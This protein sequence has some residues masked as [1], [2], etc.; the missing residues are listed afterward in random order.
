MDPAIVCRGLSKSFGAR[1]AVRSL[2]L[3]VDAGSIV[4][5]LGPNGA[6]KTTVIRV[7]TTILAPDSGSFAIAGAPHLQP[8]RIRRRVG[9]LPESSGFPGGAT[10]EQALTF[11]A[12]LFGQSRSEARATAQRLLAHVGLSD[13]A[14]SLVSRYSRGMRQRL[15]IARAL[16][17]QPEVVFLDEPT[18]GLDPAGQRQVLELI[19]SIAREHGSTV[20]LSTHLLY[21]VER[22][23]DRVVIL[24][25]GRV[26][27]D[28]TVREV[29]RLA[30]APRQARV[31][32]AAGG[33]DAAMTAL[34]DSDAVRTVSAAPAADELVVEFA[35]TTRAEDAGA[36]ILQRL[37]DAR[38]GVVGFELERGRLSDAFLALTADS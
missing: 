12:R 26:V 16:V 11:H 13:R 9:V 27:A 7:L 22:V 35:E 15:G 28:G 25:Q 2:D 34:S 3:A 20:V 37:L 29:A 36:R 24:N 18:L 21:E 8:E 23:C 17:N 1:A 4:G 14:T 31:Q 38:I 5:L 32:L 19:A 6:G 30:A 33:L 10:G